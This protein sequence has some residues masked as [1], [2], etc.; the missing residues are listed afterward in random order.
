MIHNPLEENLVKYKQFK[1]LANE[2][3]GRQKSLC[4]KKALEEVE[5]DGERPKEVLQ[6][7]QTV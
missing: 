6:T 4:E 5:K 2:T 1:E 3:I 7:L